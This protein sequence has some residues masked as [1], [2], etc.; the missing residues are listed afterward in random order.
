MSTPISIAYW[1]AGDGSYHKRD[2]A[3]GICTHGF[4]K[5][6]VELLISIFYDKFSIDSTINI[7]RNSKGVEQYMIRIPKREVFKLQ[8]SR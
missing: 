6:E 3:V 8:N 1:I 7:G 2:G 4:S 5:I